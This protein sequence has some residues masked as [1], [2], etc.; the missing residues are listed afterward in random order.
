MMSTRGGGRL[1]LQTEI[2]GEESDL[3]GGV[4]ALVLDGELFL[5]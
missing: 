3:G 5:A 1:A 2:T 4:E